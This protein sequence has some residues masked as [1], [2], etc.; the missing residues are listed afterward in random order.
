MMEYLLDTNH[1]SYLQQENPVVLDHVR[2]LAPQDRL[3]APTIGIGEL[4]LGARILPPG[5]RQRQLIRACY[6]IIARVHEVVPVNFEAAETYAQIGASIRHKGRPIP[7][8]DIWIAAIA[9]V[10]GAVLVT[11]DA[12]FAHVNRLITQNWTR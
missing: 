12:H 7:I 5:R 1:L 3:L 2:S 4:L 8:N 11:N 6:E 10:R 9:L